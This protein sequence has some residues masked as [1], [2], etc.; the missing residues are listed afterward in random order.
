M[1]NQ[2]KPTWMFTSI[3]DVT[4]TFLLEHGIDTVFTDLDNT[5]M[6]WDKHEGD[7]RLNTWLTEMN[8]F[9]IKVIVVS[10]NSHQ[11]IAEAVD[12]LNLEFISRALKPTGIGIRRALKQFHLKRDKVVMIG[13]Q[14][15]TDVKAANGS[16]I[17]SILVKP[18]VNNDAWNTYLNRQLERV[19]WYQLKQKY[20]DL[21]W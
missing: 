12:P 16:H 1:L 9:G 20:P 15:L 10:N 6:P 19:V 11:R 14:L 4:P 17:K 8:H 3:F 2:F 7:D 18:L 21:H 5:L 13:D